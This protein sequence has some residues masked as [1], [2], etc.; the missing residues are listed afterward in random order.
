[1]KTLLCLISVAISTNAWAY[2]MEDFETPHAL[3]VAAGVASPSVTT[4]ITENPAGLAYNQQFKIM[5]EGTTNTYVF[6]TI[7]MGGTLYAGNGFVGGGLG[8]STFSNTAT[9]PFT[10]GILNAGIGMQITAINLAFGTSF[11]YAIW[12]TTGANTYWGTN[13]TWGITAGILGRPNGPLRVGVSA[14]QIGTGAEFVGLGV[15]FEPSDWANITVDA[16]QYIRGPGT[17][18]KPG[19]AIHFYNFQMGLGYGIPLLVGG[20]GTSTGPEISIGGRFGQNF[21]AEAYYNQLAL[22]SLRII[23][24]I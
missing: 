5:A 21:R 8:L 16:N 4:A 18:L 6:D 22:I 12:N 7:G 2:G 23:V 19:L 3:S 13:A 9:A 15:T 1:M 11:H 17:V 10:Q 20:M 14:Y 24:M